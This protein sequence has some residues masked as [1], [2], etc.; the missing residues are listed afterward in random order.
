LIKV[1]AKTLLDKYEHSPT[2]LISSV[3]SDLEWLPWEFKHYQTVYWNDINNQK[4]FIDWTASELKVKKMS[5]WYNV[6]IEVFYQLSK[7]S[8][9][10]DIKKL[11]G[12][13]LL[14]KYEESVVLLLSAMYPK[15]DW[16][17]WRFKNC[18]SA[19]FDEPTNKKKFL[20]WV[21][22]QVAIQDPSDWYN[23][24]LDVRSVV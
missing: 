24:S 7:N 21:A 4:Y 11:G 16:L 14:S 23:V 3:Y 18:P 20:E 17:P 13:P 12:A 19:F 9:F 5:D 10:Q 6:T 22:K 15:F 2:K 8:Y 1:G